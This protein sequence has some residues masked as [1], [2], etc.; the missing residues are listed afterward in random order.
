MGQK[1]TLFEK[2]TGEVVENKEKWPKNKPERT[3]KRSGEAVENTYLWKKRTENEPKTKLPILLKI[4]NGEKSGPKTNR[5]SRGLDTLFLTT[6]PSR[7]RKSLASWTE[8]LFQSAPLERPEAHAPQR[9]G[10]RRDGE[11]LPGW[12]KAVRRCE[13]P[14]DTLL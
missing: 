1:N 2:R 5:A 12:L 10:S 13:F 6:I 4:N 8:R 7:R 3:G 14:V 11:A 9:R